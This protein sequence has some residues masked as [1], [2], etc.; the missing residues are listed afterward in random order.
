MS[1]RERET[2]SLL[3]LPGLPHE[4]H[5]AYVAKSRTGAARLLF[6]DNI[7][8][9]SGEDGAIKDEDEDAL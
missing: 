7:V 9:A 4:I 6:S 2:A 8:T 1:T 3:G 5:S